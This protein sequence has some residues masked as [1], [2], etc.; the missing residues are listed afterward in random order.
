MIKAAI[1]SNFA[2]LFCLLIFSGCQKSKPETVKLHQIKVSIP[3]NPQNINPFL[4]GSSSEKVISNH[5]FQPLLAINNENDGMVAILADSLPKFELQN[6]RPFLR[7]KLKKNALW[8]NGKLVTSKD[9][10][11]TFKLIL[12]P[13]TELFGLSKHFSFIDSVIAIDNLGF[14]VFI[15]QTSLNTIFTSG[16]IEIVPSYIFDPNNVLQSFSFQ[17]LRSIDLEKDSFPELQKQAE[18]VL[19][20]DFFNAVLPVSGTGAYYLK[21]YEANNLL[22]LKRKENWWGEDYSNQSYLFQCIPDEISFMVYTEQLSASLALRNGELDVLNNVNEQILEEIQGS[23]IKTD[24]KIENSITNAFV[25]VGINS[26]KEILKDKN[27]RKALAFLCNTENYIKNILNNQ[28]VMIA[29]PILPSNKQFFNNSIRNLQ[30]SADSVRFYLKKAGWQEKDNNWFKNNQQLKLEFL[31]QSGNKNSED[32]ALFFKSKAQKVG[33]DIEL[34]P[35]EFSTFITKIRNGDFEITRLGTSVDQLYFDYAP[36][37]HSS[38]IEGGKNYVGF[39][40]PKADSLIGLLEN[41]ESDSSLISINKELQ[42]LIYNDFSYV[43]LYAPLGNYALRK[44]IEGFF[45]PSSSV[46]VWPA[47]LSRN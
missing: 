2:L 5:L 38:N 45:V 19:N 40:N 14:N 20:L 3:S 35:L 6:D 43:F 42:Q 46:M 11:T 4:Y 16:D 21:N 17:E 37:F 27:T 33:I 28:A 39:S 26:R 24:F 1:I 10:I 15:N 8:P 44:D 18:H 25:Y 32:F 9:V 47:G 36:L 29:G 13:Y 30:Y 23:E 22:T 31:I 12:N 41:S 34:I 7:Y